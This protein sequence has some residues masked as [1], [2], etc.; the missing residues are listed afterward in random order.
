MPR[1][2]KTIS[3]IFVVLIATIVLSFAEV[4]DKIVVIVNDE[5]I[6]QGELDKLLSGVYRRNS[7]K[8]TDAELALKMD[9]ARR[10]LLGT[11]IQDRLLLSEAKRRNIE[12]EPKEVQE[13]L[14][15]ARQRFS[16]EEE[17]EAALVHDNLTLSELEKSYKERIMR[18][19]VIDMQT[20]GRISV[21]PKEVV[22]FYNDNKEGFTEGEKIRLYSILIRTS[23]ERPKEKSLELAKTILSRLEEGGD[24]TSLATEYSNGPYASAGGDMGWVRQGELM[25]K[26]NDV[27]FN[28]NDNEISGI[29]ETRLGFHIFKVKEKVLPRALE[30]HEVKNR[31]EEILYSQKTSEK[32]YAWIEKL[33]EDAYIA[34]R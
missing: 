15:E 3:L 17:F 1:T 28:L 9:E 18:D 30:F 14:N 12:V 20:R 34:F 22:D 13:R 16:S 10:N 33:K 2:I 4:M 23:D 21:S 6:T 7:M 24:F 32:L 5:I 31:I 19:K 26:I 25:A 27:V 29:L 11:L 8:Y